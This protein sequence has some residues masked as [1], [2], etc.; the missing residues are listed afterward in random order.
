[1]NL[2]FLESIVRGGYGGSGPLSRNFSIINWAWI[3]LAASLALSVVGLYAIDL[4]EAS[5]I[6]RSPSGTTIRQAVFLCVGMGAAMFAAAPHY[7]LLRFIAWPSYLVSI[8]L[9]VFLLVPFVPESIVTPRNGARGWIN[10]GVADF[11]PAEVAKIAFVLTMSGF[12][13][14]RRE[15][16]QLRGLIAPGLIAAVPVG[17]ITLQPDLGS[18]SLFVPSLFA[19]LLAAGARLRHLV[20]IVIIA[21]AAAPASWPILRDHQKR[22]FVAIFQQM[23]GSDEGA[24]DI[25]YQSFT[26]QRLV[27][28]GRYF[29]N[30]DHSTRALVKYNKLPEAHNDMVFAVICLRFGLVG[31]GLVLLLYLIWAVA[32]LA[33]AWCC[34]DPFG[35]VMIVGLTTFI[36]VQVMINIGMTVGLVP[37]IGVTLPFVSYGGS[38]MLTSWLMAGLILNAGLRRPDS[39]MMRDDLEIPE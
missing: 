23:L 24:Q 21:T 5:T 29:G 19:M 14:Y 16:T 30:S 25:N 37:I 27:G 39:S 26:A 12:L 2:A 1:M 31:G 7:R 32:A 36:G 33:T 6:E 8:A 18:A 9:L 11:Q 15:H 17:L 22:R 10:M 4:A 38:S 3:T 34:R 13:R 20:L 35:R 28:A